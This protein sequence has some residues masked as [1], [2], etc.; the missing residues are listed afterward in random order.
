[1][2]ENTE[3]KQSLSEHF[4]KQA[5]KIGEDKSLAEY[6]SSTNDSF[7]RSPYIFIEEYISQNDFNNVLD[8]CCGTG[9]YSI[10]PAKNG[11]NVTGLDISEKSIDSARTRAKLN[12]VDS[13][14]N[15][16]LADAEKIP[17][18]DESFDLVLSYG[19]LSYL[20]MNV[21]FSE[22]SRVLSDQ[23][24]LI[25]VD[26]LGHNPIFNFNRKR[27]IMNYAPNYYQNLKTVKINKIKSSSKEFFAI[28]QDHY[29]DLMS[30]FGSY[31][32]NIFKLN[33]NPNHFVKIDSLLSQIP[34]LKKYFFKGVFIFRKI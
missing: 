5:L 14:C 31:L 21:A 4:D 33:L 28:E 17:F 16:E 24:I 15:F 2:K 9:I 29:F 30:V 19:S 26:S 34:I 23:G 12:G 25:V 27:N 32:S 11:S 10:F 13:H 22:I 1:M 6:G 20:E 7:L 18:Q 8:Y 3:F